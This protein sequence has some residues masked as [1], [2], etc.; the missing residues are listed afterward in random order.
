MKGW[1]R[2]IAAAAA[3]TLCLTSLPWG[4]VQNVSAAGVDSVAKLKLHHSMIQT[5]M[6]LANL[7][8]GE[9]LFVGGQ[10]GSVTVMRLPK[11]QESYFSVTAVWI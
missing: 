9:L 10:T 11:K 6:V 4:D 5:G 8:A 2:G 1:K 3:A 7:K